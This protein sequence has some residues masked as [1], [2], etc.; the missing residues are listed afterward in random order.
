[1][2]ELPLGMTKTPML[3]NVDVNAFM[4]FLDYSI[5]DESILLEYKRKTGKD[6]KDL[7]RGGA[8]SQMIDKETG[9]ARD[10]FRDFADWLVINH[11]GEE[12]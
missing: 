11:W 3:W 2:V 8:L 10:M 4:S 7:V 9:Y 5:K 1:M 6:M 12:E